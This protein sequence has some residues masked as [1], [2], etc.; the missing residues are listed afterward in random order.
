VLV[1]TVRDAFS[2]L[3]RN[4][5]IVTLGSFLADMATEMLT[6]I[7]PIFMT[8][9]LGASGSIVGLV[10]GIAQAV[11]N[12]V[13]GL[14]GPIS[15]KLR[16]RKSIALAGYL[17]SAVAKP[18]MGIS[19]VWEGVFAGRVIDRIGAGIVSAPRDALVSSSTDHRHKGRGFGV[20]GVGENAGAFFGPMLTVLLFYIWKLDIRTIFYLAF[21]PAALALPA[22]SLVRQRPPP[23][24]G[25]RS[26]V[27]QARRLPAA[28]W[29]FL[30]VIAIF[31]IGNSS[32]SFLILQLQD[33]GGSVLLTTLIYGVF[34]FIAAATAYPAGVLADKWGRQRLLLG[35]FIVALTVYSGFAATRAFAAVIAIF[36]AYGLYE[37]AFRSLG[38]TIASELAPEE[39]RASAIGWFSTTAGVCQL[40]ANLTAGALWDRIGHTGAFVYGAASSAAGSV[41]LVLLLRRSAQTRS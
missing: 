19:T 37:G 33:I 32:N 25:A 18:V 23:I 17:L 11:R 15:D 40:I 26:P 9:V 20:E 10:D 5:F 12:I 3:S 38:R 31:S 21:I 29:K 27:I 24:R 1:R 14:F 16:A 8:Q 39:L 30:I 4:T 22:L 41:A 2:G 7:L 6:P 34:N 13:D 28:Y 36:L 35:T